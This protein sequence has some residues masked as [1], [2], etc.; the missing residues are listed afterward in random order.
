E[1]NEKHGVELRQWIERN[2][3]EIESAES[4][5]RNQSAEIES[6]NAQVEETARLLK[7]K[8][9]ELQ[10]LTET[11]VKQREVF[12]ASDE[13]L[14][15]RQMSLSKDE[16]RL[17]NITDDLRDMRERRE[18]TKRDSETARTRITEAEADHKQLNGQIANAR[19]A[20]ET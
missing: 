8:N 5:L 3:R 15:E 1:F 13:R 9:E 4:K 16:L 11:L 19:A 10:E 7:Q 20:T 6:A 18:T 17:S 2:R 14:R 12:R